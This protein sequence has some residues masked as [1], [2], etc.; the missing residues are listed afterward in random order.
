MAAIN[1]VLDK[2]ATE[3]VMNVDDDCVLNPNALKIM[4][5]S[6][7]DPNIQV[8]GSRDIANT[9]T[10][11]EGSIL[12]GYFIFK[13]LKS[14]F[15]TNKLFG[16]RFFSFRKSAVMKFP[17]GIT[18]EDYW[19]AMSTILERGSS[20]ISI[21]ESEVYYYPPTSWAETIKQI[22]RFR[23]SVTHILEGY[24]SFESIFRHQLQN[25]EVSFEDKRSLLKEE[26][27]KFGYN[28]E[29]IIEIDHFI[30]MLVKDEEM[31][32]SDSIL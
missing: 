10:L 25:A 30:E 3:I 1:H 24:P 2:C 16:G 22:T 29:N 31:L 20:V 23:N 7:S 15:I 21:A 28:L 11:A 8:V 13:S 32:T 5:D 17:D 19:L 12:K 18:S 9:E 27:L 14:R 26:L 6:F 4:L